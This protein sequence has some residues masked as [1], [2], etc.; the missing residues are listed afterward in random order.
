ME[1]A[2]DLAPQPRERQESP[3][4][5]GILCLSADAKRGDMAFLFSQ[6]GKDENEVVWG[7]FGS[8]RKQLAGGRGQRADL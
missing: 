3:K 4:T 7:S 1:R 8:S 5:I 2:A 6:R